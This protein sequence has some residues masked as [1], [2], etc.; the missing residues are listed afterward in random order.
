MFPTEFDETVGALTHRL[1]HRINTIVEQHQAL[2]ATTIQMLREATEEY[3]ITSVAILR[4]KLVS[5]YKALSEGTKLSAYFRK[6]AKSLNRPF[7]VATEGATG[8]YRVMPYVE[9]RIPNTTRMTN[10]TAGLMLLSQPCEKTYK[11]FNIQGPLGHDHPI[12]GYQFYF[13][14]AE[15]RKL[16]DGWLEQCCTDPVFKI[17]LRS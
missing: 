8:H 10:I 5:K 4:P 6:L 2:L 7:V 1:T 17:V 13:I 16:F 14:G 12:N 11:G 9:L 3:M 15:G